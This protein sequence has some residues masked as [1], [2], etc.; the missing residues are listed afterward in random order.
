VL[1]SLIPVLAQQGGGGG[2]GPLLI[3]VVFGVLMYLMLFRP[4]QKRARAQKELIAHLEVGDEVVT[5]GGIY[6]VIREIDDDSVV[7]EIAPD[8]EVRFLK[9]AIARRLVIQEDE[10]EE[11]SDRD[12]GVGEQS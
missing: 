12:E 1:A 7:L 2:T 8:V 3:L 5:L 9:G 4:Q 6:G 11:Y 10:T